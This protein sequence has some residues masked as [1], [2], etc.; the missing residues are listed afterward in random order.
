MRFF[1]QTPSSA[2]WNASSRN[3]DPKFTHTAPPFA[4]T[5]F[6]MAS[7]MLRGMLVSARD[8]EC[9]A[10]TGFV[11]AR[12]ASQNVGSETCDTSTIT[13]SR[14]ISLTTSAPKGVRPRM[15]PASPARA[16]DVVAVDQ[17]SVM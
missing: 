13:P 8:D 1:A 12:I 2:L 14:F 17:V 15:S 5:A 6:N 4:A 11:L 7:V 10:S 16:A 3:A 9:V